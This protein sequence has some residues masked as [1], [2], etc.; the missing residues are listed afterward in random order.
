VQVPPPTCADASTLVT[1]AAT[2]TCSAGT[3]TY[4]PAQTPCAVGCAA[5]ACVGFPSCD[6]APAFPTTGNLVFRTASKVVFDRDCDAF[7]HCGPWK[8]TSEQTL[9][10]KEDEL[11]PSRLLWIRQVGY[12]TEE[13]DGSSRYLCTYWDL[14]NTNDIEDYVDYVTLDAQTGAAD[15][16]RVAGYTCDIAGGSGGPRGYSP[17]VPVTVRL[18][19]SCLSITDK[20]PAT[21]YGHQTKSILTIGW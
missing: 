14:L 20:D 21:A 8:Q 4:V 9:T 13:Q 2:G 3:C 17:G 16:F 11:S 15:A 7:G 6:G 10:P 18:G 12:T 5:G 1:Y 19:A